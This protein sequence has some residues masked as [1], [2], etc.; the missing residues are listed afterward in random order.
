MHPYCQQMGCSVLLYLV[1]G[2]G[3]P[4]NTPALY[5]QVAA[6]TP[7]WGFDFC[8]MHFEMTP[9]GFY[10]HLC[11]LYVERCPSDLATEITVGTLSSSWEMPGCCPSKFFFGL[12]HRLNHGVIFSWPAFSSC[13]PANRHSGST[14]NL[15][16]IVGGGVQ[17][18]ST[19]H[20]GHLLAYC[21]CPRW[22]WGWSTLA[23]YWPIVP[24]PDD[25]EDGEIGGMN[26]RGNRST[27]TK[28]APTP[29]CVPQ[30]PLDQTRD[31]TRAA[32]VGSQR[33]TASAMAWP[34]V[35][36]GWLSRWSKPNDPTVQSNPT[37]D[38]SCHM[39]SD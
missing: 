6:S 12:Q 9:C 13:M 18:G 31:W 5:T 36:H 24:A 35:Y 7:C 34:S 21:T 17:T 10:H 37:S 39:F 38:T 27:R 20:V 25:C 29:L 30:I 14:I 16:C 19:W 26:G 23:T 3:N 8:Q 11:H 22:L 32:A 33:V 28:P 15:I 1:L 2:N 4:T